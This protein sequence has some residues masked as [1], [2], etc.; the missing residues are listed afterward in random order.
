MAD[1]CS[2]FPLQFGHILG[3]ILFTFSG[4]AGML[5]QANPG[6]L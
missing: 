6:H 3:S 2:F 1:S 4:L 5:E